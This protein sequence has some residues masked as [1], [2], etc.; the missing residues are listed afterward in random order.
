[1]FIGQWKPSRTAAAACAALLLLAA[2]VR[3]EARASSV[4]F[5]LGNADIQGITGPGMSQ[6]TTPYATLD[7]LEDTVNGLL[8]FTMSTSAHNAGS[9]INA[10][11]DDIS[12][13]TALV[14]NSDFTL[15]SASAGGTIGAGGNVSS[16]GTFDYT[17]GGNGAG[18][19]AEPYTFILHFTG[20]VAPLPW[21]SR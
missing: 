11:F 1:M 16:F 14:L 15:Q 10:V 8:T 4:V 13:N 9:P 20:A 7:I 18:A 12:F 19:R 17:V 21:I 3:D 6:L 2:T 5:D